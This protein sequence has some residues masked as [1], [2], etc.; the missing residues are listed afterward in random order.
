LK[1]SNLSKKAGIGKKK[2]PGHRGPWTKIITKGGVGHNPRNRGTNGAGVCKIKK[3][4]SKGKRRKKKTI[5][6]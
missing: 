3:K 1:I 6:P 2:T 5:R 4:G